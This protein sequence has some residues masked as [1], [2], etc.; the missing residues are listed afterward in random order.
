M[1]DSEEC[2]SN[3]RIE[4]FKIRHSIS[5]HRERRFKIIHWFDHLHFFDP[6]HS[7]RKK[8]WT[9]TSLS[10][11]SYLPTSKRGWCREFVEMKIWNLQSLLVCNIILWRIS[12]T[13][14]DRTLGWRSRLA[15]LILNWCLILIHPRRWWVNWFWHMRTPWIQFLRIRCWR[16]RWWICRYTMRVPN[17]WRPFS[18]AR[19]SYRTA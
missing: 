17:A 12:P 11:E 1:D 8:L 3:L 19:H 10:L 13:R 15:S 18:A 5:S 14:D 9:R 7:F 6:M 4:Y 2:W 16:R